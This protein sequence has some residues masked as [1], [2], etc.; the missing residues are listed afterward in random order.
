MMLAIFLLTYLLEIFGVVFFT[1][2]DKD[3]TIIA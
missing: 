3:I 2:Y 1:F